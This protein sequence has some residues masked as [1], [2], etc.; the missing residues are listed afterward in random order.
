MPSRTDV[1]SKANFGR[2]T[3]FSEEKLLRTRHLSPFLLIGD[4]GS[5]VYP[6]TAQYNLLVA[7]WSSGRVTDRGLFT[8]LNTLGSSRSLTSE[9]D[10][11]RGV[12]FTLTIP[13][14]AH[15]QQH[16]QQ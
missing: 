8:S 1:W 11:Q 4:V 3:R 13:S 10:G 16:V 12:Y 14:N 2:L 9:T 5:D 15:H 6:G 7:S